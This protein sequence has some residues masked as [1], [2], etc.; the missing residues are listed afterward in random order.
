MLAPIA[1]HF[2]SELWSKFLSVPNRCQSSVDWAKDVLEQSW[3]TVSKDFHLWLDIKVKVFIVLPWRRDYNS[4]ARFFSIS[5]INRKTTTL[6]IP[7]TE[8]DS[9]VREFAWEKAN[10]LEELRRAIETSTIEHIRFTSCEGVYAMLGIIT[11]PKG[12]KAKRNAKKQNTD[13]DDD[14]GQLSEINWIS[15]FQCKS[16]CLV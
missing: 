14:D 12:T 6:R 2:A 5:Q 1:P 10:E 13:G 4:T 3:P 7:R 9:I 8:A 15:C 16:Y 11:E